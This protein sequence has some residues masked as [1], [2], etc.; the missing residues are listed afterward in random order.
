MR[1]LGGKFYV[2][3]NVPTKGTHFLLMQ[4]NE[5]TYLFIFVLLFRYLDHAQCLIPVIQPR[6][7]IQLYLTF[8]PKLFLIFP[9]FSNWILFYMISL[10][11][12]S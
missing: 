12:L 5:K 8:F 7:L 11:S 3:Q 1:L 4:K 2:E 6:V 10:C 9:V